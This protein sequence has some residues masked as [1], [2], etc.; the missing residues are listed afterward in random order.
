MIIFPFNENGFYLNEEITSLEFNTIYRK[1][2]YALQLISLE[3]STTIVY[4][5]DD[6]APVQIIN[7]N[8]LITTIYKR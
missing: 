1:E 3:Y 5:K 7:V 2:S 6:Y 8:N 4:G